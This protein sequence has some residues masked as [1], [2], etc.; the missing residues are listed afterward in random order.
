MWRW[1]PVCVRTRR[2]DACATFVE[3]EGKRGTLAKWNDG[4]D[5]IKFLRRHFGE[6]VQPQ[7]RNVKR[8]GR[9]T[10][11]AVIVGTSHFCLRT[12]DRA[13]CQIQQMISVLQIMSGEPA[14]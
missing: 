7:V 11:G 6:A 14:R 4:G 10:I 13:G 2:P 8:E 1:R 9:R 12:F 3:A 5:Q